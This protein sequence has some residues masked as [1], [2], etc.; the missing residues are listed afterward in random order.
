MKK[1]TAKK[2]KC[3]GTINTSFPV[4]W[5]APLE[6][7]DNFRK[8]RKLVIDKISIFQINLKEIIEFYC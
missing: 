4:L 6:H 3:R 8:I 1:M 7:C 2:T 5:T